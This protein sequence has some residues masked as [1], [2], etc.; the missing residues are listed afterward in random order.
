[1]RGEPRGQRIARLIAIAAL[2]VAQRSSAQR[3]ALGPAARAF[4]AVDTNLIALTHLRVIDGTGAPARND[5]TILIRDGRIV[6]VGDAASAPI[7]A[8][9]QVLDLTGKSAIPG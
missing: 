6:L 8:G 5:Q 2:A 1:M 9:A 4:A 3:P 7:P